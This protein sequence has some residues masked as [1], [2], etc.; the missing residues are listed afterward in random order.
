[1][2]FITCGC[3]NMTTRHCLYV[4]FWN[5]LGITFALAADVTIDMKDHNPESLVTVEPINGSLSIQWKFD[6]KTTG[7]FVLNTSGAGPLIQSVDVAEKTVL[8]KLDPS[9]QLTLGSR[10]GPPDKPKEQKWEV[11]FDN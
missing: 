4:V 10:V 1:M 8:S 6:G 2:F 3:E 5:C 9:L 11:F 7:R